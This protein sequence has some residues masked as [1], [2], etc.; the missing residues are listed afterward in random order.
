[1]GFGLPLLSFR[2]FHKLSLYFQ[3]KRR[4]ERAK[5]AA[6]LIAKSLEL[7]AQEAHEAE[8]KPEHQAEEKPKRTRRKK[9][10][11]EDGN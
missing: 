1:M 8:P 4:A 9:E 10:A 11:A 7:K 3:R 6:E 5:K 2:R